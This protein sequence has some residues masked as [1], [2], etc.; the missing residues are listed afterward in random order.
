MV[1]GACTVEL[2]IPGNDS[3]KGK[4]SALK[5]LIHRLRK[6]FNLS[7]AE[8][9]LNDMWQS[10]ELAL[11][12]VSNDPGYVDSRLQKSVRWIENHYRRVQVV[13]WRIEIF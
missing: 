2:Y 3:L 7:V 6:E 8:V 5:P 13:D 4:R 10:A 1:I 11:V 9:H 12:T